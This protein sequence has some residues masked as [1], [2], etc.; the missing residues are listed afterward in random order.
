MG[1]A[2]HGERLRCLVVDKSRYRTSL[3]GSFAA[4]SDVPVQPSAQGGSL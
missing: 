4:G 3:L 2:Q 1:T